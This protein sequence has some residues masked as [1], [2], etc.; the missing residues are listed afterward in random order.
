ML[1]HNV[2]IRSVRDIVFDSFE[3][4]DYLAECQDIAIQLFVFTFEAL[5][6]ILCKSFK[7][8]T[9]VK[10]HVLHLCMQ[11]LCDYRKFQIIFN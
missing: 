2:S 11:K 8:Y 3:Y 4:T 9:L 6:E 5:H 1:Q 7:E 10:L